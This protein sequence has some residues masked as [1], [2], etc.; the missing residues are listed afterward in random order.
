MKSNRKKQTEVVAL[1]S[2]LMLAL[3]IVGCAGEGANV[4][5]QVESTSSAEKNVVSETTIHTDDAYMDEDDK[6]PG[7]GVTESAN[8]SSAEKTVAPD[9]IKDINQ[10]II[11]QISIL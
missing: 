8:N 1:F 9:E 11:I 6:K 3:S 5:E 10:Q 2:A 4:T 7:Q